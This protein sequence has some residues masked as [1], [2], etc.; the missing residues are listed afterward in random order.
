MK[1]YLDLLRARARA[2]HREGRPHRHRHAQRV[3]LADAL[4][5][6]RGLS[7]G[8]DQEAAP[9]SIVH[10]LLWFLQGETNIALPAART[11]SR[12]GTNGPTQ[13]ASSARSTASSGVAG[14]RRTAATIDQIALG[15]RRDQAQS[16]F[17]P[18]DRQR[19]ERRRPAEDGAAA[20]PHAVPVLRRR[21]Q[22]V[23]A[24]S[25]SAAPTS[26]SACRSTSPATRC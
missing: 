2:R 13:T 23:A 16:G 1:Q 25:T 18:A 3:R 10:E 6:A 14:R 15:D 5:P 11:A 12:S 7:A 24:S 17:A 20:L 22:A 26:S 19:L 9:A 8:H 4:R 21:R